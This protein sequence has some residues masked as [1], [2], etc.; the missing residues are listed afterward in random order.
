MWS[1]ISCDA[2]YSICSVDTLWP[3]YLCECVKKERVRERKRFS[4]PWASFLHYI[5]F[6]SNR[7]IENAPASL[8]GNRGEYA[9]CRQIGAI[10][11]RRRGAHTRSPRGELRQIPSILSFPRPLKEQRLPSDLD[12]HA[13][14][15]CRGGRRPCPKTVRR[16]PP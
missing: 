11:H 6:D 12:A 8:P 14:I 16:K 3:C 1:W 9:P 7:K 4:C 13:R 10:D 15:A 5:A 2:V